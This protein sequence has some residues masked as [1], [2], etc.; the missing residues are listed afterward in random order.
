MK[1]H[2]E[3]PRLTAYV[4]GELAPEEAAAV[5]LAAAEDPAIRSVLE[6]TDRVRIALEGAFGGKEE[7]LSPPQRD[8]IRKAA[9]EAGRN[10]A[11]QHLKS[12]P[13]ARN[14]WV[15]PVAIAALIA[16]GF[17]VTTV[18]PSE[19]SNGG[20]RQVTTKSGGD[21]PKAV[22]GKTPPSSA[23]ES[24]LRLPLEAGRKSLSQI[25]RAFRVEQRLPSRDE[26]RI[27]ELL[28][29]F[30]LRAK[31][32]VAL[33]GGCSVGTEIIS[34]PWKPSGCLVL[35][36]VRGAR[37]TS[38]KMSLE[39]RTEGNSVVRHRLIG[40]SGKAED[41]STAA[42]STMAKGGNI[43]LVIE[44]EA[45]ASELGELAWTVDNKPA[46]AVPLIRDTG[47][48]PSDDGRFAALVCS[49]GLWLRHEEIT[50]IDEALV[51]GLAREVASD[52]LVADRYD[53][54]ELVDQAAKV[55][56]K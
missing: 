11:L 19:K 25:S 39:F 15:I 41:V 34:C 43:Y 51:L 22:L 16:I 21:V 35:V 18:I 28:N 6:E 56:E 31:D 42:A 3:D 20:L 37:D 13:R 10:G 9:K 26:V 44:V 4:L 27:E 7:S 12:H 40:W 49:F 5:E 55:S 30:P 48:E 45:S 17:F 1:L 8:R 36:D 38:K 32:S 23:S 53:F 46:P 14:P 2:Q 24:I 47:K 54:L 29:A 52:G 50:M 33:F